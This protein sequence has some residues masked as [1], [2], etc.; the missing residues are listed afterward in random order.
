MD[1]GSLKIKFPNGQTREF[2]LEQPTLFVGQA[3]GNELLLEDRSVSRR[4]ARFSVEN[5]KLT[6]ED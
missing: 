3:E 4:H 5:G 1:Y 6:V 2:K